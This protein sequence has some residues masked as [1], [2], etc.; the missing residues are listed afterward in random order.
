MN[1][2]GMGS[3]RGRGRGARAS[4]GSSR[5]AALG[6]K[7]RRAS[8]AENRLQDYDRGSDDEEEEEEYERFYFLSDKMK[9]R[10]AMDEDYQG[11]QELFAVCAFVVKHM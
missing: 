7:K 9:R 4:A 8:A 11:G 3:R 5:F 1:K 10:K 6:T 2:L